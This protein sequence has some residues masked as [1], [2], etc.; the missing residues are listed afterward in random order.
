MYN[1]TCACAYNKYQSI[2]PY[3]PPS[4]MWPKRPVHPGSRVCDGMLGAG[5][6]ATRAWGHLVKL[7]E[8]LLSGI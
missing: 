5:L 8:G 1:Y 7:P 2:Y 3:I 6:R 4:I